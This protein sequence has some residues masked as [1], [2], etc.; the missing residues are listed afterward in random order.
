MVSRDIGLR[1]GCEEKWEDCRLDGKGGFKF[2]MGCNPSLEFF[3]AKVRR[4]GL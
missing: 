4:R 1:N 2:K 3:R